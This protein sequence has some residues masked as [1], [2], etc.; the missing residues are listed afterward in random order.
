MAF[1][2]V[3]FVQPELLLVDGTTNHLNIK[4]R[5]ALGDVLNKYKGCIILVSHDVY[6][7]KIIADRLW[8]A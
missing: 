7:V 5:K 4:S 1:V 6:F 3:L 8:L 2:A